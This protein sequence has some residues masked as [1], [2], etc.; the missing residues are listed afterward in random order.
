[1]QNDMLFYFKDKKVP[2]YRDLSLQ[3][4][5]H[6]IPPPSLSLESSPRRSSPRATW[7]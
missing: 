1:L 5:H 2:S 4:F 6:L 7:P 3:A